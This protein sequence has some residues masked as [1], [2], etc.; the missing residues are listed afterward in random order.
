ML[1]RWGIPKVWTSELQKLQNQA[2]R[3]QKPF[4]EAS[5]TSKGPL[6][7]LWGFPWVNQPSS[8]GR[9]GKTGKFGQQPIVRVDNS[10]GHDVFG[11]VSR[12]ALRINEG[13]SFGQRTE[14]RVVPVLRGGMTSQH[15]MRD[16]PQSAHRK[17]AHGPEGLEGDPVN[18]GR[19]FLA[20]P[21]PRF[22]PEALKTERF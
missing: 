1:G 4:P 21:D 16:P 6:G 12:T 15:R 13:S 18:A 9:N 3:H 8:L 14:K 19:T 2:L 17:G 10:K 11:Q 5:R 20:L 7:T 22:V